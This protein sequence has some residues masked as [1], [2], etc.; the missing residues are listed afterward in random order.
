MNILPSALLR[1]RPL[2]PGE[3]LSSL[4]MRLAKA[5]NYDAPYILIGLAL[6]KGAGQGY[7]RDISANV[8]QLATFERLEALT[9]IDRGD[10]YA[11][12]PHRFASLITPPEI[13]IES[14]SISGNVS[15]PLLARGVAQVQLR[16]EYAVQFCPEC[17]KS[18]AYHRLIWTPV[19]TAACLEHKR[20][21]AAQCPECNKR[22]RVRDIVKACCSNC[23]CLLT[24][25]QTLSIED[26][27]FGLYSQR[28]IQSW[29]MGTEVPSLAE[30]SLYEQPPRTLYRLLHGFRVAMMVVTSEWSYFHHLQIKMQNPTSME[31]AKPQSLTPHQFYCMYATALKA[32]INWPEGFYEFLNA[33]RTV[34]IKDKPLGHA[35]G[36]DLGR[37]YNWLER[38]LQHDAY[39]FVEEAFVRYLIDYYS[40]S[41]EI[42]KTGRYRNNPNLAQELSTM[43]LVEAAKTLHTK[44]EI[45]KYLVHKGRLTHHTSNDGHKF[46]RVDR[47]E[48]VELSH[49]WLNCIGLPEVSQYLGIPQDIVLDMVKIGL[50]VA[51][52][53]PKEGFVHWKFSKSIVEEFL[54]RII[55]H[56]RFYQEGAFDNPSLLRLSA[57]SKISGAKTGLNE[58]SMLLQVAQGRLRAYHAKDQHIQLSNLLLDRSDIDSCIAAYE[59]DRNLVRSVEA[60]K[61]LGVRQQTLAHWVRKGLI[62]NISSRK[63]IQYFDRDVIENFF[64]HY[65][66][67]KEA[68]DILKLSKFSIQCLA[69]AGYLEAISGPNVDGYGVYTFNR[70]T[71]LE[72]RNS[73]LTLEEVMQLL[74]IKDRE[75]LDK[76]VEQGKLVALKP[77]R[78]QKPWFS[79]RAILEIQEN[80]QKIYRSFSE[81]T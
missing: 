30:Y 33:Y 9:R 72:W 70:R 42:M 50:L 10:L 43:T 59:A 29:L 35:V 6:A 53:S 7:A 21:L 22:I 76:W 68:A 3:S 73:W 16:P 4:L 56:V 13:L 74:E 79:K 64:A 17:L 77:P 58:A 28:V 11:S 45:I 18:Q 48:V 57:A 44:P 25:A 5:N 41:H 63:S 40:L 32:I 54:N 37:L 19:A 67:T 51:D 2:L 47:A 23:N 65:V 14:L 26:D 15:V 60:Q 46:M 12:T 75:T 81:D 34:T 31:K 1:R 66:T 8:S 20:L 36:Y 80:C 69:S 39:A 71:L 78:G 27:E 24:R 49:I 62:P 38:R 61:I 52:R 55:E